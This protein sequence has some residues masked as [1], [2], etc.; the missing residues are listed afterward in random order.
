MSKTIYEVDLKKAGQQKRYGPSIHEGTVKVI[1][2]DKPVTWND[3]V[4]KRILIKLV[5]QYYDP[6]KEGNWWSPKL[7]TFRRINPGEWLI[8]VIEE[9]TD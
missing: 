7:T 1:R 9:S 4:A 6:E 5:H 3:D 2:D 8:S